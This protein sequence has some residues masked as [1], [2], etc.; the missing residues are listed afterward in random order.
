MSEPYYS[1][2]L[3]TLYHGD[4]LDLADEWRS[5]DSLVSDPPYG[6]DWKGTE[7]NTGV[8][9]DSIKNDK[10]TEVRDE[11]LA[12]W[13][14]DRPAIMFGSQLL[15]PPPG[16]RQVLAWRKPDDSGFMGSIGG[17]RR[18]W[19]S[20]YLIGKWP[21]VPAS[22][23]SVI[24]TKGSMN[25]YLTGHPHA[26]PVGVMELLIGATEGVVVDPFAGSGS[27]LVAAVNQ[28]RKAIGVELEERYC[29]LIAKRL[30]NQTMALDFGG[31]S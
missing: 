19:E 16:T 28:G 6:I 5:A 1:D 13:G 23:S 30:S 26:K 3:V 15:P 14:P 25:A 20:I 17:F 18:N 8:K 2:D 31:V 7:Y 29:E 22:R 10:T 21:R 9:R 27:T 24:E 11:V 12:L 4:C